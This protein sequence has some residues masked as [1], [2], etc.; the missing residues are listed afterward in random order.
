M[1]SHTHKFIFVHINGC[2][3]TSIE[4][5]LSEFGH[6]QPHRV[7]PNVIQGP[8]RFASQHLTAAEFKEYYPEDVWKGYYKFSFVRNPFDRILSYYLTRY[9][10]ESGF[11]SFVNS[12]SR[13][14]PLLESGCPD[15]QRMTSPCAD[16]L[17]DANGLLLDLD[18]IGKLETI[19]TDFAEV[20]GRIGIKA[21]LV[22]ANKTRNR[23]RPTEEYFDQHTWNQ[24]AIRFQADVEQFG[25]TY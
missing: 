2:G 7:D 9:Q 15:H 24:I 14:V 23:T 17:S 20:C 21:Q 22:H 18:Y 4:E 8:L 12:L 11:K 5:S 25:Y 16:W 13:G 1:I 10:D 6:W 19:S 3:G